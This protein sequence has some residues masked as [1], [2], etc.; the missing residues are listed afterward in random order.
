M[1]SAKEANHLSK[2][3]LEARQ[4]E[5]KNKLLPKCLKT[6]NK[7]INKGH[8]GCLVKFWSGFYYDE[9]YL[10]IKELNDLGYWVEVSDFSIAIFWN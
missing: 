1:I 8:S 6:I 5:L 10:L 3:K 9:A 2:L 4:I 7:A